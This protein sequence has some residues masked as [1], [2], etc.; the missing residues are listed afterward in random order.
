M[1]ERLL[2]AEAVHTRLLA[3]ADPA[4]LPAVRKR[5]APTEVAIGMRMRDLFDTAKAATGMPL[6]EV[7]RL[8]D[9]EAYEA[10]M[11]AFCVL[12]FKARRMRGDRELHDLY[13]RRHDAIS[14][15]DMVDRA[16]PRVVGGHVTGG[17]YAVLHELAAA[18]DPLRR[19]TAVTAPLYFV[20]SGTDADCAEGFALCAGLHADPEPVVTNAVGI[21]LKHAGHRDRDALED[22]LGKY[23]EAM[24]RPSLR[25]AVEKL[26]PADRQ[27]WL[28]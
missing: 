8:M 1:S 13:L 11:A 15:W 23:A 16:A 19:R 20:M 12:D 10:R 25:L 22:F 9:L 2:T 21:Y 28:G 4:Q 27:R 26:P 17:P 18:E 24:R 6:P 14:T 7:E 3:H 5:L